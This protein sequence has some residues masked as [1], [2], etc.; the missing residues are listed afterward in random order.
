MPDLGEILDPNKLSFPAKPRVEQIVFRSIT[1]SLGDPALDV[2]VLI[3]PFRIGKRR[4][5]Y[6]QP[7]HDEIFRA[8]QDAGEERWPYVRFVTAK[9]PKRPRPIE[10]RRRSGKGG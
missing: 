5:M 8:L 1:D 2:D 7:I 3:E 6:L 4:W 9:R 10:C